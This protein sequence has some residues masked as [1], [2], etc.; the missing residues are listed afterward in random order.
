[1]GYPL[2]YSSNGVAKTEKISW[3]FLSGRRSGGTGGTASNG[4]VPMTHLL[5]SA[6]NNT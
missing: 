4:S 6:G 1:M 2:V 3:E 5:E